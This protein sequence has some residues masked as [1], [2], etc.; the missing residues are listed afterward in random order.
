M[1]HL[2]FMVYNDIES[3]I[4][5]CRNAKECDGEQMYNKIGSSPDSG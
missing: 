1:Q 2:G 4:P 5:W 3:C